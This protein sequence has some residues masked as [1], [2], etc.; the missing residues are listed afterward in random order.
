[1]APTCG[2]PG[3]VLV[4]EHRDAGDEGE[5]PEGMC[6]GRGGGKDVHFVGFELQ[7]DLERAGSVL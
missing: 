7:L 2:D 3:C 6:T 1:M 5:V 4:C